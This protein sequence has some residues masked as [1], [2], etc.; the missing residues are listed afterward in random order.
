M[1]TGAGLTSGTNNGQYETAIIG[2][3]RIIPAGNIV[4]VRFV[5]GW[6]TGQFGVEEQWRL[7]Y[8]RDDR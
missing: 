1:R 7:I 8:T 5:R 3:F 2:F 4:Q 6:S